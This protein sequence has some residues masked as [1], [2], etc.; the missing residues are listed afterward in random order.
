[1]VNIPTRGVPRF[2]RVGYEGGGYGI[3]IPIYQYLIKL[4]ATSVVKG[5]WVIKYLKTEKPQKSLKS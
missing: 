3:F 2:I 4:A 5:G 1:M